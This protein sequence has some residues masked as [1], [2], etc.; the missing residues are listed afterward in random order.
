MLEGRYSQPQGDIA[1]KSDGDRGSV[2]V[3]VAGVGDDDRVRRE[4]IAM[5]VQKI[6]E[7]AGS[8][9]LLPFDE[10]RDSKIEVGSGGV[11]ERTDSGDVRHHTGLIVGGTATE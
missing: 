10:E 5:I 9:L 6:A 2:D 1:A 11:D 3:P 7:R 4:F 8:E